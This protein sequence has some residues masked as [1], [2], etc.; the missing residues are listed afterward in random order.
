[1]AVRVMPTWTLVPGD[2]I[3]RTELHRRYGGRRQGGI[4]PS[5]QSPN[6]LIFTGPVGHQYG[7]FDGWHE[8]G[9]F[10]YT[11]EGQEGDQ[12][13]R[14]GNRALGEHV[15]N[16]I[17]IRLFRGVRGMVTYVGEFRVGE[18]RPYYTTDAPDVNGEIRKVIVFRLKP[19][20]P[21][22]AEGLPTAA[23]EW[24]PET[25]K[26]DCT[27]I[28]PENRA[29]EQFTTAAVAERTAERREAALVVAYCAYRHR[30]GLGPLKR[31]KIKPSG[32]TQSLYSDLYDPAT[33]LVIEA[34]GTVTREAIRMSLGQ[35]LDY[36][37]FVQKSRLAVLL[38]ETPR[39]DLGELLSAYDVSIIVPDGDDF[40]ELAPSNRS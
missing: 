29:T 37:R 19:F 33:H 2:A 35:L 21:I 39:K 28:E 22:K 25:S 36:Q 26:P 18:R 8:D 20:G 4:A 23:E 17:T 10:H 32:E 31:L 27:L 15:R 34:K 3:K 7:Y 6:I 5:S 13:F 40:T 16:G 11:G 9:L 30:Q 24:K 14:Q 38:P 12:Q 1:M